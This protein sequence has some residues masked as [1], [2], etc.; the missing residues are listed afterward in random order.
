MLQPQSRIEAMGE[1]ADDLEYPRCDAA[2]VIQYL[3][4]AG[5]VTFGGMGAAPLSHGEI[6]AW[7]R[8][9]GI[10]LTN[11]ESGMLRDLSKVYISMSEEAKRPS[12]PAPWRPD[13]IEETPREVDV[14][15][16]V[17]DALRG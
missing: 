8:N 9:T 13:P 12:C 10:E 2:Y 17:R 4:D 14:V 7:Q 6:E 1:R 11:W 3:F 16:R 5:P 15:K